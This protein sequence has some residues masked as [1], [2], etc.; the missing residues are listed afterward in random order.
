MGRPQ[1]MV[2]E[3][4]AI[5]ILK[6]TSWGVL[7]MVDTHG[8]PYSKAVNAVYCA[9]EHC[10]FFHCANSGMR[11]DILHENPAV[12]YVAVVHEE[13]IGSQFTT[14]YAS[15][16]VNG[17]AHFF[18]DEQE[19]RSS[20]EFLT[21]ALAPGELEKR[22]ELMGSCLKNVAMVRVEIVEITAKVNEG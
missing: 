1:R 7:S 10:L 12:R 21:E 3:E 16:A 9:Q 13:I 22:P 8:F 18:E 2:D 5:D 4:K 14:H 20:L 17:R 15:V 19:I 6:Q 11:W